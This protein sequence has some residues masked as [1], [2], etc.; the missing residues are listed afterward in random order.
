ML[1][2]GFSADAR[3]KNRSS[4]P[5]SPRSGDLRGSWLVLV[6]TSLVV[7][8]IT[9][10][11]GALDFDCIDVSNLQ[12]IPPDCPDPSTDP[13]CICVESE[14]STTLPD[15]YATL[16]QALTYTKD[17]PTAGVYTVDV[18]AGTLDLSQVQVGDDV[19]RFLVDVEI[20]EPLPFILD[21][22]G[23]VTF[24]T[25][26]EIRFDIVIPS[27]NAVTEAIF[28]YCSGTCS[29]VDVLHSNGKVYEGTMTSRGPGK[30][31]IFEYVLYEPDPAGESPYRGIEDGDLNAPN[32]S[33]PAMIT[34]LNAERKLYKTPACGPLRVTTIL[35][36]KV[37]SP[38]WVVEVTEKVFEESF[39]FGPCGATFRRGDAD[40][41]GTVGIT[42]AIYGL[43][44]LFS[45][46]PTPP[47]LDA[48]DADDNG[49]VEI[50][51]AIRTLG[52]LFLGSEPPPAPGPF[53][54]GEDVREDT[55]STC[56]YDC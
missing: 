45:G 35:V 54:C 55:L 15:A 13:W 16:T 36:P 8:A 10:P 56:V 40:A 1:P 53:D 38:T 27:V 19:F 51:D 23:T 47:C 31:F 48:A 2:S 20:G 46:G 18:S 26:T 4:Y 21:M 14:F 17:Q 25:S 22:V 7:G 44:F 29:P 33:I 3:L 6:L 30:G 42:D 50:T 49:T 39:H 41:D 11:A 12:A 52:F 5:R 28:N 32:F 24:A 9:G 34:L 43:N 37:P